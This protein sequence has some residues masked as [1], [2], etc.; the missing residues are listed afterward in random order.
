MC[1][2]QLLSAAIVQARKCDDCA[3]P[4][5]PGK[6]YKRTAVAVDGK[7][8]SSKLCR[9]CFAHACEARDRSHDGCTE[10]WPRDTARDD[11][12]DNGWRDYLARARRLVARRR[13]EVSTTDR[14]SFYAALVAA[15]ADRAR[16]RAAY[17]AAIEA[18]ASAGADVARTDAAYAD[19]ARKNGEV[20]T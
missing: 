15:V 17:S 12:K 4:I 9:T 11:A 8:E 14:S 20:A 6:L 18:V 19:A 3:A 13:C 10:G 5:A 1:H 16:A 7:L 2:G